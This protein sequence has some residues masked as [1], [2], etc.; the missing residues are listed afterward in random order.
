VQKGRE[1]TQRKAKQEQRRT[2]LSSKSWAEI[3]R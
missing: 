3:R 1:N 2:G